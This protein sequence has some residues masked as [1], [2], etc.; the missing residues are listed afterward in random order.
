MPS[1]S[2]GQNAKAP[3]T[4]AAF[5]ELFAQARVDDR[6]FENG[7]SQG[8]DENLTR[9]ATVAYKYINYRYGRDIGI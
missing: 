7:V 3:Q 8:L 2:F 1:N 4:T 9:I 6:I 5:I